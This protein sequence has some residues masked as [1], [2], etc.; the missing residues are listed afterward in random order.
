MIPCWLP[1]TVTTDIDRA[2]HYTSLWGL[3]AI[4]LRQVGA[5]RVPHVNEEKLKRRLKEHEILPATAIPGLFETPL[6]AR[7]EWMNDLLLLEE[8]LMFCQR[9]DIPLLVVSSFAEEEHAPHVWEKAGEILRQAADK[10][11]EAG[12]RLAIL[13]ERGMYCKTGKD[14]RRLMD[15]VNHEACTVAWSPAVALEAGEDPLEG[16]EA[17]RGYVSLVRFRDGYMGDDGWVET[18]PGEGAVRWPEQFNILHKAGFRGP[19]SME[20]YLKPAPRMG[21]KAAY[22]LHEWLRTLK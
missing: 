1:D 14:L 13:N 3:E 12:V 4:E 5:A 17:I 16:V 18:L 20:L 19:V 7:L 8:S 22:R 2:L 10:A 6:S 21:L 9:M 15:M 11:G